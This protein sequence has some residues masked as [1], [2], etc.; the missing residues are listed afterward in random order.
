[1]A[2]QNIP[3]STLAQYTL[4]KTA[5]KFFISLTSENKLKTQQEVNKFVRWYGEKRLIGELTAPELSGYIEQVNSSAS[6]PAE[7]L[8]P[9]KE[10]L[11]YAFKKGFITTKLAPQVKF[12]KTTAKAPKS[13]SHQAEKTINLT[14]QGYA[15]LEAELIAL[16]SERPRAAEEIRKAAADKDFR[17]NAPLEA[18]REYQS[19]LEGRIR[20]LESSLK[21]ATIINDR[22]TDDHKV[23]LGDTI[24][25]SDI[26]SATQIT[27]T[28]VD[29]KEANPFKGKISLV[30]PIG[31]AIIGHTKGDTIEVIAPAGN[32][33]Y[34]IEDIKQS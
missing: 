16:K 7:K 5:T 20:E 15:E 26:T 2:S 22:R 11:S 12:K 32:L 18:A 28:L 21:K 1:M 4:G 33:L 14:S 23:G 34:K 31:K 17:E 25:L 27:Y 3:D 8:E 19:H 30:S 24:V 13:A 10:F 9:V 6:D 29:A